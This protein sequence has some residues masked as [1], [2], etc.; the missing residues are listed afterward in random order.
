MR[1]ILVVRRLLA[2]TAAVCF[3]VLIA[4]A[5]A[6]A[7]QSSVTDQG[8]PS[9]LERGSHPLGSFGGGD[10]DVVNLFNGNLSFRLQLAG[11]DGRAGLSAGSWL[12]YNS[13]TWRTEGTDNGAG[14]TLY[15]PF[16]ESWDI[17][18]AE[19]ARGWSLFPARMTARA[20]GKGVHPTDVCGPGAGEPIFVDTLTTITFTGVDGTEYSFRDKASDGQFALAATNGC[21]GYNRGKVWYTADGTAATFLSDADIV[22]ID[23]PSLAGPYA[24]SGYV[25]LRDGTRFRI[26]DGLTTWQ[27]DRNGNRVNYFYDYTPYGGVDWTI[28]DTLG[29]KIEISQPGH[30]SPITYETELATITVT[31]ATGQPRVTRIYGNLLENVLSSGSGVATYGELFTVGG[32]YPFANNASSEFNPVLVS[33]VKLPDISTGVN[34]EY[35]FAY[36][37]YGEV[38]QVSLPLQGQIKY[39]YKGGAGADEATGV[40]SSGGNGIQIYRRVRTRTTYDGI[41]TDYATKTRYSETHQTISPGQ[42]QS[43]VVEKF[44]N[45]GDSD[46]GTE[47]INAAVTH[48]FE[49]TPLDNY[50]RNYGVPSGSG[51]KPWMEGKE[52]RTE[53]LDE[54]ADRLLRKVVNTWEQRAGT[55]FNASTTALNNFENDPRLTKVETTVGESGVDLVSKVEYAYDSTTTFNNVTSVKEYD[56]GVGS[57][58]SLLRETLRTYVTSDTSLTNPL[59]TFSGS[60]N[61]DAVAHLRSLVATSQIK[62]A[63]SVESET[64]FFYDQ[65]A[66]E[67]TYSAALVARTI[68]ANTAP[69]TSYRHVALHATRAARRGNP[70]KVRMKVDGSR[71]AFTYNQYDVC[72]NIVASFAPKASSA[73]SGLYRTDYDYSDPPMSADD[74]SFAYATKVTRHVTET[75]SGSPSVFA[76][77]TKPRYFFNTGQVESITG[78]NGEVTSYEYDDA[79]GRITKETL[80]TGGYNVVAYGPP[81]NTATVEIFTKLDSTRDTWVKKSID[82]LGRAF[83][84]ERSDVDDEIVEVDTKYDIRSRPYLV[85]NPRRSG[86]SAYVLYRGWT[87]TTYDA[88]GRVRYV[89]SLTD[90]TDTP[91]SDGFTGR[92]E[93]TYDT[94]TYDNKPVVI[95][96]DQAFK[97]RAAVSDALGRVRHVV[98]M[99][100][101]TVA[102]SANYVTD[103]S[104]DARDNLL[105]VTQGTQP[106]RLFT[107]NH[108]GWLLTAKMP[109]CAD[110]GDSTKGTT[111]YAYDVA[112]NVETKTDPRG[113]GFAV[114]TVFDELSRPLTVNYANTTSTNPDVTYVYDGTSLPSAVTVSPSFGRLNTDGRLYAVIT[115]AASA[116]AQE[117]T[118]AFYGYDASGR[119]TN[120]SQMIGTAHYESTTA[121]NDASLVTSESYSFPGSSNQ[122]RSFTYNDAGQIDEVK[123]GSA[124]MATGIAYTPAGALASERYG[125][126]GGSGS[127]YH[128]MAYNSRLQPTEIKLGTTTGGEDRL[129]LKYVYGEQPQP[130]S[131]PAGDTIDQK[132]NNG[133]IARIE[134]RPAVGQPYF[135]QDFVYDE[136]NRLSKAREYQT[137]GGGTGC[138]GTTKPTAP[139]G[140]THSVANG[141]D[142]TLTW[143]DNSSNECSFVV[144]RGNTDGGPWDV[145]GV[146]SG[147]NVTSF[148]DNDLPQGTYYYVVQARNDFD[149]SDN[150]NQRT[151]VI[152]CGTAPNAP[153]GFGGTNVNG[154]RVDLAWTD[155]SSN[156]TKFEIERRDVTNTQAFAPLTQP[157]ANVTSYQDTNVAPYITYRYRIRSVGTGGC[158]SAWV[159]SADID[160]LPTDQSLR[161]DGISQYA[162]ADGSGAAAGVDV[163]GPITAEAWVLFYDTNVTDVILS[164]HAAGAAHGGFTLNVTNTNQIAFTTYTS[165]GTVAA[166]LTTSLSTPIQIKT[167]YHIV[168]SYANAGGG[169]IAIFVNGAPTA[170]VVGTGKGPAAST[171]A[172]QIGRTLL[173]DGTGAK[174]LRGKVD[175]VR[176][177]SSV[178]YTSS[179]TP[180][181]DHAPPPP[182]DSNLKGLWKMNTTSGSTSALDNSAGGYTATLY[183]GV[184]WKAGVTTN[185][186]DKQAK[187][188]FKKAKRAEAARRKAAEESG[189]ESEAYKLAATTLWTQNYAYD[190]WGNMTMSGDMAPTT[191]TMTSAKNRIASVDGVDSYFDNC[192]NV[193]SEKVGMTTVKTYDYDANNRMWQSV[194]ASPSTTSTYTYDGLGR[195]VKKTVGSLVTTYVYNAAGE[196]VAEFEGSTRKKEYAYG[197]SGML[198]VIQNPGGSET[199][200]FT[201]PDH[202]GTPRVI[203]TGT[204]TIGAVMA[205]HDYLPFGA[206]ISTSYARTSYSYGASN[207]VKQKFTSYERDPETGLDYAQARYYVSSAGRFSS[208]D[209]VA[210]LTERQLDPQQI[211]LYAYA[212]NSPLVFIDPDG[213]TINEPT[214]LSADDQKEYEKWKAAFRST[215][216]GRS[217]WDKYAADANFTVTI[218]VG[219]PPTASKGGAEV[220]NYGYDSSGNVTSATLTLGSDFGE[221]KI[222]PESHYP[223]LSTFGDGYSDAKAAGIIAHEFG[224]IEDARAEG[225]NFRKMN[226]L[227]DEHMAIFNASGQAGLAGPRAQEIRRL[228]GGSIDTLKICRETNAE[229]HSVPVLR[230]FYQGRGEKVPGSIEK[231]AKRF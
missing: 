20:S 174:Y 121:Y 214:G 3:S 15:V 103:Y 83:K 89:D 222:G 180:T 185:W 14:Q 128:S 133:N 31:D 98:E 126:P 205:R 148:A 135:E 44:L 171:S 91:L 19:I 200:E 78:E 62:N 37:E 28:T 110:A 176:I 139:S 212:R 50:S 189:E 153:T 151:V 120:F 76:L 150:S 16:A 191:M 188:R 88:L 217:T 223:V 2:V 42:S 164:K 198:A 138:G 39:T 177:S 117:L 34:Y 92:V 136:L 155:T 221:G 22:D 147:P 70:T 154:V 73:S 25:F 163:V 124:K 157:A 226:Q 101:P 209:P 90:E 21:T 56:F 216:T 77:E 18:Q 38:D 87:K 10:L 227:L 65:Y 129:S 27:E 1:M 192:G 134:I 26:D 43:R 24:V 206:E 9:A 104:Y 127:L 6:S 115:H 33:R 220:H 173:S 54:G 172:L 208:T 64:E 4:S 175:E 125:D 93:T 60:T 187:Q 13:K 184:L 162:A 203:T 23:L 167:W 79:L 59:S 228:F 231:A 230:E 40:V 194:V 143:T 112:G 141:N 66:S 211:N 55:W 123:R 11:K 142:V 218:T 81:E 74:F 47:S 137:S 215:E 186:L 118:G 29:R 190:R 109:E 95:V 145:I 8:T 107:Y 210:M 122:T 165:T 84:T 96:T 166:T 69:V 199:I 219:V 229:R 114:T 71:D 94:T 144:R 52:I 161:F 108:A 179:F 36:N 197:A 158:T 61:P 75:V 46:V 63:S 51:Q 68:A 41:A 82:G 57:P 72:G 159:E 45:A 49:G 207:D 32:Q 183:H 119:V 168:G 160:T 67:T 5:P 169:V 80:P 195:R 181:K 106:T 182:A 102:D 196:L 130:S 48:V 99:L 149:D 131:L 12:S 156:E 53:Y 140:L 7:Q 86:E 178:R 225:P 213:L 105:S 193:T 132:L 116:T 35:S 224:H 100:T 113:S 111:T 17:S 30:S 97:R 85:S 58:G 152:G 204:G 201:T 146:T 202:L 170:S